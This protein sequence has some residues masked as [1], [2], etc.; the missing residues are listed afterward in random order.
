MA[1]VIT[2]SRTFPAYHPKKGQPTYFVEKFIRSAH[3]KLNVF[4][5]SDLSFI[6]SQ[7]LNRET[8]KTEDFKHHTIRSG[9]RWKPGD[10]FSPRIWSDKPYNSPM[11]TIAPDT[12]IV[13]TWDFE[14]TNR[15]CIYLDG[16]RIWKDFENKQADSLFPIAANDGLTVVELLQWF[17]HPKPFKGQIICWNESINY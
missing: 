9:N 17:K 6:D 10:Y 12:I 11:I 3:P 16:K 2:F 4:N 5:R 13:K 8:G 1:K 15:G 14:I 7:V